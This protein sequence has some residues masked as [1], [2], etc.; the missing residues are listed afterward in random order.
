M[1]NDNPAQ[2]LILDS[3]DRVALARC[4][5]SL[6]DALKLPAAQA[7]E[8]I[9]NALGAAWSNMSIAGIEA[10]LNGR[11]KDLLRTA[12]EAMPAKQAW[13]VQAWLKVNGADRQ[14]IVAVLDEALR[15][16]RLRWPDV[17]VEAEKELANMRNA[18]REPQT[19]SGSAA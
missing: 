5:A 17:K 16:A 8:T 11:G 7:K 12:V 14:Q 13:A 6:R 10:T 19:A 15:G 1:D 4:A 2:V 3:A 18:H 9:L